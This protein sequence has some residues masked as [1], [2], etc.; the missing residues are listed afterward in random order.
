MRF[1]IQ[2]KFSSI[3]F[4]LMISATVVAQTK[5]TLETKIVAIVKDN[6]ISAIE[7]FE[8]YKTNEEALIKK[9]PKSTFYFGLLKGKYVVLNNVVTPQNE[10]IITIYTDKQIFNKTGL[11]ASKKPALGDRVIIGKTALDVIAAKKGALIIKR[12]N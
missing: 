3:F 6:S 7:L 2:V 1:L 4:L 9:Y 11:F 12:T 10:T 5:A 8:T